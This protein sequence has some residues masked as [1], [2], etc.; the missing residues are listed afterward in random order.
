MWVGG[1]RRRPVWGDY[2]GVR[3]RPPRRGCLGLQL[4]AIQASW[5]PQLREKTGS[6]LCRVEKPMETEWRW[7]LPSK[8]DIAVAPIFGKSISEEKGIPT[9][10]G[11]V[12]VT[13]GIWIPTLPTKKNTTNTTTSASCVLGWYHSLL[14]IIFCSTIHPQQ[15]QKAIQ[16][17]RIVKS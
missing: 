7:N 5:T 11:S 13:C 8:W 12:V 16:T 6:W 10:I 2:A 9:K 14:Y 15:L 4:S 17:K 3:S 1:Q